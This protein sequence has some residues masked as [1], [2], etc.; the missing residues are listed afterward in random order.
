MLDNKKI[1]HTY[2]AKRVDINDPAEMCNWSKA[3]G[4]TQKQ[5]KSAVETVGTSGAAIQKY[6]GK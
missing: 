2:D 5:L 3:L 1:T 6:L 4:C